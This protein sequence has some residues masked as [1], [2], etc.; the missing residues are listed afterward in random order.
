MPRNEENPFK[1]GYDQELDV[2]PEL[3]TDV[4]S[5]YLTISGIL[6]WMIELRR[7]DII[8]KVLLLSS[9]IALPREGHLEVAVHVMA[10][11]GN[12]YSSRLVY[13]SSYLEIDYSVFKEC[14]WSE[15]YRND[16]EAIP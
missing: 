1:M 11:V 10:H 5:Y 9:H 13:D 2:S 6:R 15:F 12:K 8:T 3:D 14:D 16:N 4:A 7:I